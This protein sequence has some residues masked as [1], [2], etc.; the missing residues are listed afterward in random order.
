MLR[1][2]IYREKQRKKIEFLALTRSLARGSFDSTRAR[3]H[4]NMRDASVTSQSSFFFHP[5]CDILR[6]VQCLRTEESSCSQWVRLDRVSLVCALAPFA[7]TCAADGGA[8][9]HFELGTD[10]RTHS[11]VPSPF[12]FFHHNFRIRITLLLHKYSNELIRFHFV[13]TNFLS[14]HL[15]YSNKVKYFRVKNC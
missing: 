11:K 2:K 12:N 9:A 1:W 14:P 6:R 3:R 8:G 4:A 15:Q 13:Q 10:T 5:S 7:S